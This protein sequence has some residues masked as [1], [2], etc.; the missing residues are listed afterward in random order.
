MLIAI[1]WIRIEKQKTAHLIAEIRN[2]NHQNKPET[3]RL[4]EL[5]ARQREVFELTLQGK[6]NKQIMQELSIELSTL[7]TH[8]NRIYKI[9]DVVSRKQIRTYKTD[10]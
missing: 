1:L 10:Q 5:S 4:D 7:K 3:N 8:I 9:L 6:S 2:D